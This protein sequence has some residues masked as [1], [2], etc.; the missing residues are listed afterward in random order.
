MSDL[1]GMLAHFDEL[2]TIYLWGTQVSGK[3]PSGFNRRAAG[4]RGSRSLSSEQRVPSLKGSFQ[5]VV[6]HFRPGLK[7]QVCSS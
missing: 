5:L 7:Q 1:K 6:Q 2:E 4:S 3:R